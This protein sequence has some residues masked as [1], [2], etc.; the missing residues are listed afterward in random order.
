MFLYDNT[1]NKQ[2]I[3]SLTVKLPIHDKDIL[4]TY[5]RKNACT[6]F[7]NLFSKCSPHNLN[8]AGNRLKGM[9]KY[10]KIANASEAHRVPERIFVFRDPIERVVSIFKNK[11]IQQ[12]GAQEIIKNF[13]N[14]S[15]YKIEDLTFNIFVNEYI[16]KIEEGYLID[17]HL[18][19]QQWH[20]MPIVYNRVIPLNM[21]EESIGKIAGEN[22]AKKFFSKSVN[23]T[24]YRISSIDNF[25]G[26]TSVWELRRVFL[27]EGAFPKTELF[28][29]E[30]SERVLRDVYS[31]DYDMINSFSTVLV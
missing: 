14:F 12:S 4:Y 18:L 11:F 20:L 25:C 1:K 31:C 16:K 13:S 5:I 27:S 7:K 28:L 24:S 26:D 6:S 3:N 2:K 17:A 21:I 23:S 30:K 19:P 29:T 10:H 15:Q 22:I 9:A 8:E